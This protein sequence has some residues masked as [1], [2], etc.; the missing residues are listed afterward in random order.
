MTRRGAEAVHFLQTRFEAGD[1]VA[2]KVDWSRRW[3]HMQQ[4]SGAIPVCVFLFL[5]NI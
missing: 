5:R 3:D 1:K 4:H 2:L